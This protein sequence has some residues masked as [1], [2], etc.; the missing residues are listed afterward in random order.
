MESLYAESGEQ[1]LGKRRL[2]MLILYFARTLQL[3][4]SA[5]YPYVDLDTTKSLISDLGM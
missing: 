2:Q 5:V 3:E 1:S 4:S